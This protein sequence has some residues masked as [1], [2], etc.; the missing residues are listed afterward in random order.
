MLETGVKRQELPM[1]AAP[2]WPPQRAQQ[3]WCAA[4]SR[5]TLTKAWSDS[6]LHNTGR[7]MSNEHRLASDLRHAQLS[8]R[9]TAQ[10]IR[11]V[12]DAVAE[13]DPLRRDPRGTLFRARD[14]SRP[15]TRKEG[16]GTE[17]QGASPTGSLAASSSRRSRDPKERLVGFPRSPNSVAQL[18][19]TRHRVLGAYEPRVQL[20]FDLRAGRI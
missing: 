5:S 7:V 17:L 14:I 10:R 15:M 9:G 19:A 13:L 20:G 8:P 6:S 3:K 4:E 12:T 1:D 11:F 18:G 16:Q 2:T